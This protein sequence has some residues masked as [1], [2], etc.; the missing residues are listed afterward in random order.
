MPSRRSNTGCTLVA[1]QLDPGSIQMG[2][3]LQA[4]GFSLLLIQ[5]SFAV[6]TLSVRQPSQGMATCS[7][8]NQVPL[9][10]VASEPHLQNVA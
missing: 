3:S 10:P 9:C 1:D 7:A 2:S 4:R 8:I 6:K 5:R